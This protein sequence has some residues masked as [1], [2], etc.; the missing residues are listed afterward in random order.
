MV[1]LV[2]VMVL[3]AG[4]VADVE[5]ASSQ[6]V[7]LLERD[8]GVAAAMGP[9]LLTEDELLAVFRP[10]DA[11][12]ALFD[13][14]IRH[15]DAL[16]WLVGG[17]GMVF[18][19]GVGTAL[20]IAAGAP[21]VV[22]LLVVGVAALGIG[23]ALLVAGAVVAWRTGV[24]RGRAVEAWNRR[25]WGATWGAGAAALE[26]ARSQWL[27]A[28]PERQPATTCLGGAPLEHDEA[29]AA[30]LEER[31]PA[32]AAAFREAT[33]RRT[34]GRVAT[35]LGVSVMGLSLVTVLFLAGSPPGLLLGASLLVVGAA[36][37]LYGAVAS[38]QA[39]RNA[40]EA[41]AAYDAAV[42]QN[43]ERSARID[44]AG[45]AAPTPSPAPTGTPAEPSEP[46]LP[47]P[48][49]EPLRPHTSL[50]GPLPGLTLAVF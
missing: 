45:D 8:D 34:L 12:H 25:V 18:G 48:S 6:L 32:A 17:A 37:A 47:L 22:P 33:E 1:S 16:P 50:D 38:S 36:V 20:L 29:V 31:S 35:G 9:R 7:R 28:C 39:N 15:A 13:S 24:L 44:D 23:V 3:G 30:A 41:V 19:L 49:R 5:R 10:D 46:P 27:D 42:M 21:W 26:R 2:A 14:S 4:A 40:L 43:A 11:A